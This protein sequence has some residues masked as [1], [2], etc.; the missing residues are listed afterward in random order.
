MPLTGREHIEKVCRWL[1]RRDNRHKGVATVDPL[2]D[3][4]SVA[5]R[6][7]ASQRV[8]AVRI[9]EECRP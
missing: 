5:C 6:V 4:A 1:G 8:C 9:G 2:A 3:G 7:A